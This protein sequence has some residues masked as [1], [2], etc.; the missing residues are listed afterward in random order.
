MMNFLNPET[1]FKLCINGFFEF[2]P[3]P[4]NGNDCSRTYFLRGEK[5]RERG[6]RWRGKGRDRERKTERERQ[7]E[8]ETETERDKERQRQREAEKGAIKIA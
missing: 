7:R 8:T 3:E 4:G 6:G 1:F 2:L 5:E